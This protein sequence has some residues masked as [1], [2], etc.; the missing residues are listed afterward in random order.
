MKHVVRVV[1]VAGCKKT[2]FADVTYIAHRFIMCLVDDT[3]VDEKGYWI[4]KN[5]KTPYLSKNVKKRQTETCGW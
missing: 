5:V 4:Q 3:A 2:T 1:F